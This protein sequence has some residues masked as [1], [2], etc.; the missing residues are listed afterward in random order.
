MNQEKNQTLYSI[1]EL[2]KIA[3]TTIKNKQE[4][5]KLWKKI[6]GSN[7]TCMTYCDKACKLMNELQ[8]SKHS[9]ID[10]LRKYQTIIKNFHIG[11]GVA[12][13]REKR[14]E[15]QL[16]KAKENYIKQCVALIEQYISKP[17][18]TDINLLK[19]AIHVLN[20]DKRDTYRYNR[21]LE[22]LLIIQPKYKEILQVLSQQKMKFT[23][24]KTDK[25]D[26]HQVIE[27]YKSIIHLE[28]EQQYSTFF[29]SIKSEIKK[30]HDH[31]LKQ[32]ERKIAQEKSHKFP[33]INNLISLYERFQQF[34]QDFEIFSYESTDKYVD[35]MDQLK[36][37]ANKLKLLV[38]KIEKM[39]S[40]LKQTDDPLEEIQSY[41]P[42]N[43]FI[44][45]K[46]NSINY[47]YRE[48]QQEIEKITEQEKKIT[49]RI[50]KLTQILIKNIMQEDIVNRST[51]EKIIMLQQKREKLQKVQNKLLKSVIAAK[52]ISSKIENLKSE[53]KT[54]LHKISDAPHD[55]LP[56]EEYIKT[57][58]FKQ[59]MYREINETEKVS[60]YSR[61]IAEY[62]KQAEVF[63]QK[64]E[65][66]AQ[67]NPT[68]DQL[69]TYQQKE[70]MKIFRNSHYFIDDYQNSSI[71][72]MQPFNKQYQTIVSFLT[73]ARKRYDIK[74]EKEVIRGKFTLI[75][76]K[77]D[78]KYVFIPDDV[79]SFGRNVPGINN[80]VD[81]Q[82]QAVSRKHLQLDFGKDSLVDV[83]SA[84]GT[85]VNQDGNNKIDKFKLSETKEF[86]LAKNVTFTITKAPNQF[87]FLHCKEITNKNIKITDGKEPKAWLDE[88]KNTIFIKVFTN[89]P[90]YIDKRN[91]MLAVKPQ[92]LINYVEIRYQDEKYLF[93][94]EK[95]EIRDLPILKRGNQLLTF[96][97]EGE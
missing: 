90:V 22:N 83:G 60:F 69:E 51:K 1:T 85:Y 91:G 96:Y 36:V 3:E 79:V 44:Q 77:L 97:V 31:L 18:Q 24:E 59:R 66:L 7:E 93:T 13:F 34:E 87:T 32:I 71:I 23:Y 52:E 5:R 72:K 15:E 95:E 94:D 39:L 30:L 40:E 6:M 10:A 46:L 88:M 75:H 67:E 80:T 35:E 8:V 82:I 81:L 92:D 50:K 21:L 4:D 12:R 68:I 27:L 11:L 61:K 9:T 73:E 25:R 28:K 56:Y 45:E 55:N 42:I 57:L 19:E 26:I 54:L 29:T 76:P 74:I 58:Q 2:Q 49:D 38:D 53:I 20:D 14:F 70:I 47:N 89:K 37:L 64:F 84:N 16:E 78:M 63:E 65:I 86:N 43:T 33:S 48:F 62:E 17:E 41:I